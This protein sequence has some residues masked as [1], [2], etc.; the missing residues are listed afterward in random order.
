MIKKTIIAIISAI[1]ASSV[2]Y[3]YAEQKPKEYPYEKAS[4]EVCT[5]G[6]LVTHKEKVIFEITST[7]IQPVFNKKFLKCDH[8]LIILPS[9]DQ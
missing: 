2:M 3:L 6:H 1:I 9:K 8:C 4:C 7:G 5:L